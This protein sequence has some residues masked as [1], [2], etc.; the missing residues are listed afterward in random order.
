MAHQPAKKILRVKTT[1]EKT[2]M[3]ATKDQRSQSTKD[4]ILQQ[5]MY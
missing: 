4:N 2:D 1:Q 5:H 3:Q